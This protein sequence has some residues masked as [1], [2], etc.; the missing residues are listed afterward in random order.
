MLHLT[1]QLILFTTN[2]IILFLMMKKKIIIIDLDSFILLRIEINYLMFNQNK[3][4]KEQ[5]EYLHTIVLYGGVYFGV[6]RGSTAWDNI[7]NLKFACPGIEPD[8]DKPHQQS[9]GP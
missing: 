1:I 8:K 2:L 7:Q 9:H 4:Q 5:T 6:K 3:I